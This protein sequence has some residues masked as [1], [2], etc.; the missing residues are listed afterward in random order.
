MSKRA[1]QSAIFRCDAS[2]SIGAGHVS[3]CVAFAEALAA[4]GWLVR[5][6]VGS[7]T[8]ATVPALAECAFDVCVLAAGRERDLG[9]LAV[10]AGEVADLL[11]IDHYELDHVFER[12]CRAWSHRIVVFDDATG[13]RHDCDVLVDASASDA[14]AYAGRVPADARLLLGP[15]YALMRRAFAERRPEALR[16]R[17]GRP[18]TEIL[19]SFGATDPLNAASVV[20]ASLDRFADEVTITVAMS[21]QAPHVEDI[22][23]RLRGRGRLALDADM[24]ELMTRVGLAIG[25]AGTSA[26][27]RAVLGLPSIVVALV[28]NQRG[29][30]R[31]L[32]DAN[33]A[34]DAGSL[35]AE[36][37]LRIASLL[38]AFIQDPASR[39]RMAQA[40]SNIVD[41]QG[42][43]RL[44]IAAV[45]EARA[46][47]G[48]P[49]RMRLAESGDE[50]W[51]LEL[52]REPQTRRYFRN[53]RNPT[54]VEHA[55][56]MRRTL[57][58]PDILLVVIDDGG[59]NVGT[60]R[61]DRLHNGVDAFEV[62]IAIHPQYHGRGIG[63]AALSLAP[64]LRP[65]ATLEAEIL[66]E[67]A[68]SLAL[69]TRAGYEMIGVNRYRCQPQ[70][71]TE[72]RGVP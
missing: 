41:G 19:V 18:V 42:S 24:A 53:S 43:Q 13:R 37:P 27:E 5:F 61:L 63:S 35:D 64:R 66:P 57:G 9:A 1:R 30:A 32:I 55:L 68:A 70:P 22:R 72:H 38:E 2:P 7:E 10:H 21:S 39:V 54:E 58:N 56:W 28:E 3:R 11:V 60:L 71:L 17:D 62:S 48:S 46:H 49:V 40:A 44:L 26:F 59:E 52:Q 25:A 12:S 51:L 47:D 6:V 14:A 20:L 33:A 67:N 8:I 31:M 69:F 23:R 45:G 16:R 65:A 36:A 15:R 29:I 4:A 50:A 34:A